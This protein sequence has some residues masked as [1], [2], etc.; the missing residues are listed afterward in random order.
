MNVSDTAERSAAAVVFD[1]DGTLADT[2]HDVTESLNYALRKIGAPAHS[3]DTVAGMIGDGIPRLLERALGTGYRATERQALSYFVA[4]YRKHALASTRLYDGIAEQLDLLARKE[5]PMAVLSNK[6]HEFTVECC[7]ALLSRWL[8]VTVRGM[9]EGSLLK[10]DP[11]S[12]LAIAAELGRHPN[13]I[14]FVGDSP[15]DVVTARSAG[16]ISVAAAWG[17]R[18]PGVLVAEKPD[19]LVL[20]PQDLAES[21]LNHHRAHGEA[22]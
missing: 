2:L 12:A 18:D 9:L 1:L 13:R 11:T 22:G 10:P 15:V 16:M 19:L 8:F 17:Y 7:E 21:L 5:W 20:R 4:H 6:A 3:Q 14:Y